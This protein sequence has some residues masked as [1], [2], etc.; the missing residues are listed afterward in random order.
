MTTTT[1]TYLVSDLRLHLGDLDATSYRY[2]D[3]W[4]ESALLASVKTLGSWW[5]FKYLVNVSNEAYRNPY[6]TFLFP[7]PPVIENQDERPI[8]LMSSVILKSGSLQ[9]HSWD[10]GSWRDNELA[11]SNI[12][13]SKDKV[14]L[15]KMDWDEL[16]T[17]LTPPN[18]VLSFSK[19][20]SL[21]GY[22]KNIY[23][24]D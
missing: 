20:L 21:P 9:D 12:E 5:N 1:L 19:K 6:T 4:L 13:G 18:K 7:E 15:L 10:V 3:E 22:T 14:A 8:I 2:L 16:T 23:E 24:Y 11:Y 17:L